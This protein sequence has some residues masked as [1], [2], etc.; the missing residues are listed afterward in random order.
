MSILAATDGEQTPDPAVEVAAD[1][2]RQYDERLTVLHV[3][4]EDTFETLRT[5]PSERSGPALSLAPGASYGGD[6]AGRSRSGSQGS[7]SVDDA[8]QDAAGV[9]RTVVAETLADPDAATTIGCVGDVVSEILSAV[10]DEQPR[11]LVIGGRKRTPV[12]KALF[13][14]TTQSLLL[15][16]SIPVVTTMDE[17]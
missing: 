16:A 3:M 4:A 12:G 2:A 9:A 6:E 7:Y 8:R 1:L 13:G 10:E 17:G 15:E 11:Y 14:S 5:P